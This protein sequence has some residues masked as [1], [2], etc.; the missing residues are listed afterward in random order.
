VRLFH[1]P[2]SRSTRVLWLLEEI[3]EPYDLTILTRDEKNGPEHGRRHPL[4]RVPVIEEDGGY[5]FE[6]AAICLDIADRH[7]DKGLVPAVGTHERALVYQWVIFAVTELEPYGGQ[8]IR[9]TDPERKE[10]AAARYGLAV[11]AV[12]DALG[13]R[14]FLVGDRFTVADLICGAVLSFGKRN[15]LTDAFPLVSA[16]VERLDERPARVRANERTTA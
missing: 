13:D 14:D 6:S 3:G 10:A 5:V 11:G 8:A 15:G 12:Q 16:Y 7:L 4:N 2:G 9:E 1:L